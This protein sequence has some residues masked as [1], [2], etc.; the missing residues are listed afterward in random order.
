MSTFSPISLDAGANNFVGVSNGVYQSVDQTF[1]SPINQFRIGTLSKTKKTDATGT[2]YN[3]FSVSLSRSFTLDA[4]G[5]I[6]TRPASITVTFR[7][8]DGI[9]T[10]DEKVSDYFDSM[11]SWLDFTKLS[12]ILTGRR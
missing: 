1:G 7:V 10:G 9:D 2:S 11:A 12:Q 3:E 4:L 5:G 6:V 8:P